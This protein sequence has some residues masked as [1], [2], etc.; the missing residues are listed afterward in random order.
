MNFCQKMCIDDENT[1]ATYFDLQLLVA[2][3]RL[4][5]LVEKNCHQD[6]DG[7]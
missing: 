6:T 5:Q 7:S 2:V 3:E 4:D 1:M